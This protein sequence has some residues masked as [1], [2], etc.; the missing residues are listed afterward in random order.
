MFKFSEE[1]KSS[2]RTRRAGSSPLTLF[3][4]SGAFDSFASEVKNSKSSE[5]WM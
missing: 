3:D 5:K 4:G 1:E 2:I